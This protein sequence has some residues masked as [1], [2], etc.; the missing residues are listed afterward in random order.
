MSCK[1]VSFTHFTKSDSKVLLTSERKHLSTKHIQSIV[2]HW[3]KIHNLLSITPNDIII[4]ISKYYKTNLN[5]KIIKTPKNTEILNYNEFLTIEF[6]GEKNTGKSSFIRQLIDKT[7]NETY[8]TTKTCF[9]F[10]K[11]AD[12]QWFVLI[13]P[14]RNTIIH[15]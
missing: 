14:I 12:V 6:C 9:Y 8:H 7:F 13:R 4:L 11:W 10:I 5:I 2:L 15:L 1:N 3:I